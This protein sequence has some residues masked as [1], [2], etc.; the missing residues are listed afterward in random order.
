MT[1][2]EI[3]EYISR[4]QY[5]LDCIRCYRHIMTLSNCNDCGAAKDCIHRPK[6]GADVRYNCPLWEPRRPK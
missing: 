4:Q 1:V 6:L 5:L 3:D 2:K